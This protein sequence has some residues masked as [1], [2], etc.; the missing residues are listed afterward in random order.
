MR[1]HE[2]RVL[3]TTLLALLI[4]APLAR[5][6][7]PARPLAAVLHDYVQEALASNLALRGQAFDVER[8]L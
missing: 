4:A 2:A 3:V 1:P 6:E 5:A 8:Q 7:P